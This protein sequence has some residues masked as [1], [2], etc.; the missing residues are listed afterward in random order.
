MEYDRLFSQINLAMQA[1]R[2]LNHI[3]E[4]ADWL[5]KKIVPSV[6][7]AEN[8]QRIRDLALPGIRLMEEIEQNRKAMMPISTILA[9]VQRFQENSKFTSV[10]AEIERAH[11]VMA[12]SFQTTPLFIEMQKTNDALLS[13]QR[14][15]EG[16]R[17]QEPMASI[18]RN[19]DH[20]QSVYFKVNELNGF[21]EMYGGIRAINHER[22]RQK[23]S[24]ESFFK[25]HKNLMGSRSSEKTLYE[26]N[27]DLSV[28]TDI[29][30]ES[31]KIITPPYIIR[32]AKDIKKIIAEVYRSNAKL[33][34]IKSR[35]FEE[36]ICELLEK[37]GFRVELTKQ[38]R[39][40]GRDIIA[41]SYDN[42][43][44]ELKYLIE[45]KQWAQKR[46]VD[47]DVIRSFCYTVSQ[48]KANKGIIFTTSS[49][50]R[51]ARQERAK[52]G[53]LLLDLREYAD[54]I[55]WVTDYIIGVNVG[56]AAPIF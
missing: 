2:P 45:C 12:R 28:V 50:T 15:V 46:K 39:D 30:E 23:M 48:E 52:F 1:S 19:S 7:M 31:G 6:K 29:Q 22:A 55:Q 9:D 24:V 44:S 37:R 35:Q 17:I 11:Q 27:Y 43:Q 26:I 53:P 10:F 13:M 3:F 16:M 18:L 47:V 49:F 41:M 40:G 51:D 34:T 54:I 14:M 20:L 5:Q 33:F 8:M 21:K 25:G 36:L 4:Q 32:E 38:T 42:I 56:N